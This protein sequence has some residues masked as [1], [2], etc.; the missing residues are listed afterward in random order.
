MPLQPTGNSYQ[1]FPSSYPFPSRAG[2]MEGLG[3]KRQQGAQ[4]NLSC[5]EVW[6]PSL[7]TLGSSLNSAGSFQVEKALLAQRQRHRPALIRRTC[8]F[9]AQSYNNNKKVQHSGTFL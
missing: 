4:G 3:E 2:A 8:L 6:C 7:V 5:S 1:A 9:K